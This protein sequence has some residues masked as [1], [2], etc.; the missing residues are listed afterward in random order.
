MWRWWGLFQWD[1]RHFEH[2]C[3]KLSAPTWAQEHLNVVRID[4]D[5]FL[6]PFW[7]ACVDFMLPFSP[8]QRWCLVD[9]QVL[10][11][12]LSLMMTLRK[13][14]ARSAFST[15]TF[16]IQRVC[17]ITACRWDHINSSSK[18]GH[19]CFVVFAHLV[20]CVPLADTSTL[21]DIIS[22]LYVSF[23]RISC[24]CRSGTSV[25]IE[26]HD[27]RSI[28]SQLRLVMI[29]LGGQWTCLMYAIVWM[30]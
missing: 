2:L 1:M 13:R 10:S 26:Q 12:R 8:T 18:S 22:L 9:I 6:K 30:G 19:L 28:S 14:F 21:H 4:F 27:A 3:W 20:L 17:I 25:E 16:E 24:W 23:K 5:H 29:K 15:N 7:S 11:R